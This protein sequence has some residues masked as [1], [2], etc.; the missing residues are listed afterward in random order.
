M[1]YIQKISKDGKFVESQFLFKKKEDEEKYIGICRR[2]WGCTPCDVNWVMSTKLYQEQI[3]EPLKYGYKRT[4]KYNL[5]NERMN[6]LSD[7]TNR[8]NNQTRFLFEL[9]DGNFEKLK[10]LEEQLKNCFC[11][12]PADKESVE[13]VMKMKPKKEFFKLK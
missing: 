13:E 10:R 12:P 5:D 1:K 11:N 7:R 8:S 6:W 3:M 4:Y 9:V 2:L